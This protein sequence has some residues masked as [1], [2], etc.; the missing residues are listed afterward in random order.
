M[1]CNFAMLLKR[2]LK[3][4]ALLLT[5]LVIILLFSTR[6]VQAGG[7]PVGKHR[8]FVIATSSYFFNDQ[9]WDENGQTKSYDNNGKYS[10]F[11]LSL[12]A[13]YGFSRR[14]SLLVSLPY[15]IN[16]FKN[17]VNSTTVGSLGDASVGMSYY[18][19]N[20]AYRT[21]FSVQTNF[22]F[23]VYH[24]TDSLNH[25]YG[26]VGANV[27]FLASGDFKIGEKQF[28]FSG[29]VGASQYF[30]PLAPLQL[31]FSGTLGFTVSKKNQVSLTETTASSYSP[32]KAFDPT[33]PVPAKDFTYS[34]LTVT[35]AHN[36]SRNKSYFLSGTRFLIGKNTGIGN[37]LSLGYA[38]K[39]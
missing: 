17:T 6:Q 21:Y 15:T 22:L 23:P 2:G 36:I 18:I 10:T 14:V 32:S 4:L 39:F 33:S 13:E 11:S 19:A 31:S 25:G 16:F 27:Q 20:I 34:E 8:L 1:N 29:T 7:R 5:F 3:T 37:T 9:Y 28:A 30:G 38:Y 35:V 26:D 12:S 24:N